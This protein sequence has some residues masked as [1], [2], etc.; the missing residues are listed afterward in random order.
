[1]K[2][3]RRDAKNIF[4]VVGAWEFKDD[5]KHMDI[6]R[7]TVHPDFNLDNLHHDISVLK[8]IDSI[9][10]EPGYVHAIA[11]PKIE[12]RKIGGIDGMIAGWGRTVCYNETSNHV[13]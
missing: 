9:E 5:G 4:I 7:V 8:T 10:F 6:E 11:L 3:D 12:M 1:M 2:N 13:F